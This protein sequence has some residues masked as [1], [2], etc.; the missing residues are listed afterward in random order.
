MPESGS[1]TDVVRRYYEA[2]KRGDDRAASELLAP[3]AEFDL[4]VSD[5]P[6]RGR[7]EIEGLWEEMADSWG[8]NWLEI[9]QEFVAGDC[10]VIGVTH[11]T[12]GRSSG[13][14]AAARGA[15]V[16]TVRGGAIVAMKLFQ[17]VDDAC[18]AVGLQ[19]P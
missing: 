7:G 9:E 2:R 19:R 3:D 16:I 17:T 14:Q 8:E 12:R 6:Y 13:V 18:T 11:R 15:Q 10:V 4:S 1:N 5:S